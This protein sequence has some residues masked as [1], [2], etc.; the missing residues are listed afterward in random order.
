MLLLSSFGSLLKFFKRKDKKKEIPKEDGKTKTEIDDGLEAASQFMVT[1]EEKKQDEKKEKPEPEPE[2]VYR[3]VP[4]GE[5]DP[6]KIYEPGTEDSEHFK[7]YDVEVKE[8]P[9][10]EEVEIDASWI[11]LDV[12][13]DFKIIMKELKRKA[14]DCY[15]ILGIPSN[16]E[17]KT[18]H[19]AYRKLASQYHPD[20]GSSI[21]GLTKDQIMEKIR[22]INYSKDILLNPTMR[23]FHDQAMREREKEKPAEIK[24]E[25]PK[26]DESVMDL[27]KDGSPAETEEKQGQT[28]VII[29][30]DDEKKKDIGVVLFRKWDEE[31]EHFSSE[32]M[33]Y[34]VQL[35]E[36]G[37][38]DY[39]R[40][41]KG[42][43]DDP[44]DL[45]KLKKISNYSQAVNNSLSEIWVRPPFYYIAVPVLSREYVQEIC[46]MLKD[47]FNLESIFFTYPMT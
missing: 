18:I 30:D 31:H 2:R 6:T 11:E 13:K 17:T 29:D 43:V 23:A 35:D 20:R 25:G 21:V 24:P 26:L 16:A 7:G 27:I 44:D 33:D 36:Q 4:E 42:D 19:K 22:E 9:E 34:M 47:A 32:F 15:E 1:G 46:D 41:M 40:M 10:P 39:G 45:Y 8:L 38:I 28:I 3:P 5:A 37:Y 12:T 14:I